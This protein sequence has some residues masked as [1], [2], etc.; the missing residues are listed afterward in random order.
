M[1][2]RR[3]NTASPSIK[4]L[5]EALDDE[6]RNAAQLR[7]MPPPNPYHPQ[8]FAPPPQPMQPFQY[9]PDVIP[10]HPHAVDRMQPHRPDMNYDYAVAADP[11]FHLPPHA[12]ETLQHAPA[13]PVALQP[14]AD[15]EPAKPSL[16]PPLRV[17]REKALQLLSQRVRMSSLA[18][19]LIMGLGALAVILPSALYLAAPIFANLGLAKKQESAV[20]LSQRSVSVATV[21]ATAQ[22]PAQSAASAAGAK[23]AGSAATK[24]AALG[25]VEETRAQPPAPTGRLPA[26]LQP[27]PAVAPPAARMPSDPRSSGMIARAI[28]LVA[29]GDLSAA[30]LLLTRAAE[31]GSAEAALHLAETYDPARLKTRGI[32]GLKGDPERARH[33]YMRAEAL[34]AVGASNAAA[35]LPK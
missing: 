17:H 28:K 34:G 27:P 13:P 19:R 22:Q 32:L 23:S 29:A 25:A 30:R 31:N 24:T 20:N 9:G 35:H 1:K 3:A 8:N 21:A 2:F 16:L 4:E 33:W 14:I 6:E 5:L 12:A 10:L 18:G 15:L 11:A 7:A 26:A